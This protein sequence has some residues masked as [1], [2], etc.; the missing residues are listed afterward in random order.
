MLCLDAGGIDELCCCLEY[1]NDEAGGHVVGAGWSAG[2]APRAAPAGRH[3]ADTS[4]S[5]AFDRGS[6]RGC[7][8]SH[9]ALDQPLDAVHHPQRSRLKIDV[10]KNQKNGGGG[11]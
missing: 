2:R 9:A 3:A 6:R 7:V 5:S 8:F 1:A 11:V 10:K 4:A